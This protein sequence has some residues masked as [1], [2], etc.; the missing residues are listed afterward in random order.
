VL[1]ELCVRNVVFSQALHED[2][3]YRPAVPGAFGAAGSENAVNVAP[4]GMTT[5]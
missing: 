1:C 4:D 3:S 2:Y 5:Y